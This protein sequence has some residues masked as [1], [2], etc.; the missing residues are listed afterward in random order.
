MK[1]KIILFNLLFFLII[2]PVGCGTPQPLQNNQDNI[3]SEISCNLFYECWD[4]TGYKTSNYKI[5]NGTV[6]VNK[7]KWERGFAE[8]IPV[9][10]AEELAQK[11]NFG[12]YI[13]L[14]LAYGQLYHYENYPIGRVYTFFGNYS[15]TDD[16][17][18]MIWDDDGVHE[19]EIEL[20]GTD[21]LFCDLQLDNN[22][23]YLILSENQ[24][25]DDIEDNI[26]VY[27]IDLNE[28]TYI[29]HTLACKREIMLYCND[30]L[31]KNKKLYLMNTHN[32][33]QN[34]ADSSLMVIDLLTNKEHSL[35]R[36]GL[37]AEALFSVEEM[38]AVIYGEME[39]GY[40][41]L[42]PYI[43]YYDE[44]LNVVDS[45]T[46]DIDDKGYIVYLGDF[47]LYDDHLYLVLDNKNNRNHLF[48]IY[49]MKTN[50]RVYTVEIK[51]PV[52][53]AVMQKTTFFVN[54]KGEYYNL[55]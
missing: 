51:P 52:K 11:L 38:V 3:V 36:E 1:R 8:P 23:L 32:V 33:T 45:R 7:E 30:F 34:T 53:D 14:Q 22:H 19:I 41:A 12:D 44:Q 37:C 9:K 42:P 25:D 35:E 20:P 46:L 15:G 43:E 2:L 10:P 49:N 6:R 54:E 21:Y 27:E 18:I 16:Y 47:L 13:E 40:T 50:K 26:F 55:P 48:I 29:K 17:T 39:D 31:I 28:F 4:F 5:E 24:E